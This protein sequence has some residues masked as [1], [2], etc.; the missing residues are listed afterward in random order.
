MLLAEAGKVARL[1]ESLLE[2]ADYNTDDYKKLVRDLAGHE[3]SQLVKTYGR[4]ESRKR[5]KGQSSQPLLE[6]RTTN[7][8]YVDENGKSKPEPLATPTFFSLGA[9]SMTPDDADSYRNAADELKN[10][11]F[12]R[13]DFTFHEPYMRNHDALYYFNGDKSKQNAFDDALNNL[14]EATPFVAFGVGVRKHAYF[15]SQGPKED[16]EHQ[17]EYARLLLDGTQWVPSS[18][19]RNWLETGMRFAPKSNSHPMELSDM[20]SRDLYEWVRGE[21]GIKPYRWE[22]FEKKIYCRDDGMRGKFGVK[23]FPDSDIRDKIEV[24]R[25]Q[26]GAI[27]GN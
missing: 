1:L 2:R 16:A 9:I 5:Y 6:D 8:L 14:I 4:L 15:E 12:G 23:I 11:F 22:V 3:N 17:L 25:V 26:C 21:C 13:S 7:S 18:A 20:F 19:F 10:D 27:R 24:H